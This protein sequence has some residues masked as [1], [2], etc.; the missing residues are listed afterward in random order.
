MRDPL[1]IVFLILFAI[2]V[3]GA[4][5][6]VRRTQVPVPVVAV[7]G[8]L[9]DAVLFWLFALAQHNPPTQALVVGVVLG[10]VFNLLTVTAASFFR[11]G[12]LAR[13]NQDSDRQ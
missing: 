13:H 7:A 5:M 1:A 10:V 11:Q 3:L 2:S 8:C 6:I 9:I 12:E 4:Y